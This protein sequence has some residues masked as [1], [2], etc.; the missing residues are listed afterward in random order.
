[1]SGI[2][3][4]ITASSVG[5]LL[6]C[7]GWRVTAV[8][9]DPYLNCDAGTMS[10]F[11]HG[12]CYVLDDGGET[13]LDLGNYER[14]LDVTLTRDHSLTSGKV[15]QRV[16]RRERRG[17]YLGETVQVVPHVTRCIT[18]ELRRLATVPVESFGSGGG[19]GGP[20]PDVCMVELGGTVGDIESAAFVEALR[21]LRAAPDV[22][23][24]HVHLSWVPGDDRCGA[25]QEQKTKPTQHGVRTLRSLGLPPDLVACRCAAPLGAAAR[26]K[27]ARYCDV[28]ARDV[29]SV[30][31]VATLWQVPCVLHEQGVAERVA[32]AFARHRPGDSGGGAGLPRTPPH[33]AEWEAVVR[34][35]DPGAASASH[36]D[37]AP[38]PELRIA[39]VG[40]Y[41]GLED[42]YLSVVHALRHAAG[43]C[44]CR[45]AIVWVVADDLVELDSDDDATQAARAEAA[46]AAWRTLR[47]AHGVVVPG[48]FGVRGIEG[49][50]AGVAHARAHGVP[51]LGICLGMQI[52]AVEVARN[53]LGHADANSSEFDPATTHAVVRRLQPGSGAGVAVATWTASATPPDAPDAPAVTSLDNDG[54]STSLDGSM[55][56]GAHTTQFTDHG[57]KLWRLYGG[58]P[59]VVERHRHRYTVD[60]AWAPALGR[61]GLRFVGHDASDA[62]LL[63]ACEL[64][65]HPYLVGVQFH[66]EFRSRPCRPS[67]PFVGL[68]RAAADRTDGWTARSRGRVPPPALGDRRLP[69]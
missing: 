51:L 48:G 3:K 7:G 6:Q 58:A 21:E 57:S 30:H 16:L 56:L 2:G 64:E 14:F 5:V 26:A 46:T 54:M 28:D 4:G 50:L 52:I 67:P 13:D 60:P 31:D 27:L 10:P 12:E 23:L 65:K 22:A 42:S 8:K 44:R 61:G 39:I 35:L 45:L 38:T 1:M 32:A 36:P 43:A 53:V 41:T 29:I 18:D 47:S 19:G 9:I 69:R 17:D 55:R 66:P 37:D 49:K 34:R 59:T 15:Y 62:S 68:V 20:T 24:C 40:K 11:E 25:L 63:D 33:I